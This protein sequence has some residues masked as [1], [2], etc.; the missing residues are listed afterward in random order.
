M[1]LIDADVMAV[2]ESEAYMSAQVK[3]KDEATRLINEVVHRKIQMLIA[4]T[5]TVNVKEELKKDL[6]EDALAA[7]V[8]YNGLYELIAEWIKWGDNAE[9]SYSI[10]C[11]PGYL[12]SAEDE[13][14]AQLLWMVAVCLYGEYGT[15]PRYGWIL[16]DNWEECKQ[17]FK[18][19]CIYWVESEEYNGEID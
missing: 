15:S 5:P 11:P 2:D 10:C 16:K 12:T 13:P 9:N 19:L 7:V 1:R 14:Q 8:W 3:V 6:L 17:F 18:R 4:D